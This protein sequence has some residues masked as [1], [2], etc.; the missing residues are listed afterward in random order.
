MTKTSLVLALTLAAGS[1]AAQETRQLS[2]HEHGV[3]LLNVA[4][5]GEQVSLEL[6]VPG[7][8]IVGFEHG[9]SST[10]DQASVDAAISRL[11]EPLDLFM[12]SD[13]AGCT[14]TQAEAGLVEEDEHEHEVASAGESHAEGE[15]AAEG[16]NHDHAGEEAHAD[17]AEHEEDE[18]HSEFRAE[19]V[20]TCSNPEALDG[21][22]FAY[23]TAFPNAQALMVQMISDTGTQG[24]EVT[25]D[26]P[27]LDLQGSM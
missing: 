6:E 21:L 8:D 12:P 22:D 7:M 1:V 3:G 4:V 19:Y 25:R 18:A 2:A 15:A 27:R 26:Q 17:E 5:E 23:F 10:E 20:L 16:E 24:F 14:V 9:P 11:S 13:A